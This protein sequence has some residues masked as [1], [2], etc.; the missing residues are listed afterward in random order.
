LIAQTVEAVAAYSPGSVEKPVQSLMKTALEALV[1]DP[2]VLD[3]CDG[4]DEDQP[5]R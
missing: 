4:D 1:L 2:M 3:D 5:M